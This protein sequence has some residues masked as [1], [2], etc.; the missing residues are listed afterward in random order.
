MR[1]PCRLMTRI[2]LTKTGTSLVAQPRLSSPQLPEKSGPIFRVFGSSISPRL[3]RKTLSA[4]S[5]YT[6]DCDPQ[7]RPAA[8]QVF[9]GQLGSTSYGPLISKPPR[10]SMPDLT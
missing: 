7:M 1:S 8:G 5:G 9:L 3:D 10:C 4:V 6:P 2:V